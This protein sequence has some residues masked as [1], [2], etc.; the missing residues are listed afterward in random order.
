[1]LLKF[2]G[3]IDKRIIFDLLIIFLIGLLPVFWFH[4]GTI[5]LG[6]DAGL[7]FDPVVHF[8]DRFHVWSQ[9][10]G[11][12][13]DQSAALLGAFFIHGIEALLSSIG[14]N[15][16]DQQKTQFVFWFLIPGV[17]MYFSARKLWPEK[18][19]L[20]LF[21]AVI[22]MLNF[23]LLQGWFVAE[24]TKFSLYTAFPIVI[25]AVVYYLTGR[26]KLITAALVS[27]IVLGIFN[28]GGSIPLYGGLAVAVLLI[29]SYFF[30]FSP[31]LKF[32]KK[33]IFYTI[34]TSVIYFLLNAYWIIPYAF[35]LTGFA[36]RDLASAGGVEGALQWAKYL[37]AQSTF[38]N[39]FRGQGIPD[40][41]LNPY[42]AFSLNFFTNPILIA[43]SFALPI[44]AFSS[45]LVIRNKKEAL[46][47]YLFI[48]IAL[49]GILFSSGPESQLGIIYETLTRYVPGF[50]MFRSAFFKFN[51]IVWFSYGILIGFTLDKIIVFLQDKYFK[52]AKNIFAYVF[53]LAAILGY[54]LY[55]YPVLDGSFFDY[56]REPGFE[57][58]TRVKVP[59]YIFEFGNWINQRGPDERYLIM[60]QLGNTNYI[61]YDW[62]Y[63]SIA[64]ITS[65]IS[66]NSF[67]H[68]NALVS[69]EERL[70][71][72]EMYAA[73][74]KGDEQSFKDFADVFAID[75]I[76]LQKDFDW[77]NLRWGTV[78]PERYEKILD[79]SKLFKLEK[80][81]GKWKV[82]S[83]TDRD[84]SVRINASGKL[85][86]L[87]GKLEK[88]ASHPSFDPRSP[89]F[90]SELE[91]NNVDFYVK[92]ASEI[93]LAPE[94]QTCDLESDIPGFKYY[95][96]TI[97]PGSILYNFITFR[98][99]QIKNKSNDF[100]S[101]L[102]FYITT[103]N[104]RI[105]E[106]K[107]MIDSKNRIS[108]ILPTLNRYLERLKDLNN[109]LSQ[110][111]W[112]STAKEENIAA[113]TV[114]NHILQQITLMDSVYNS[115]LVGP[116]E[117][118]V[119]ALA[120][121]QTV[122]IEKKA[123]E[124]H[125][126]TED[127]PDKR[128]IYDMPKLGDYEL[129][130]KRGSLTNPGNDSSNTTITIRETSQVL[131]P[132]SI[133]EDW[134][135]FGHV[136]ITDKKLHINLFDATISNIL[137]NARIG[138][139]KDSDGIIISGNNATFL[140]NGLNKCFY[141]EVE[142]LNPADLYSL[143]F[144]YRNFSDKFK[145]AFVLQQEDEQFLEYS[146]R[147]SYVENSR[148]FNSFQRTIP[149][150]QSK[151]KLNFCG[152]FLSLPELK[153]KDVKEELDLLSQD[154]KLIEIEGITLEKI[155]SPN[156]VLYQKQKEADEENNLASYEKI[157]PVTYDINFLDGDEKTSLIMRESFGKY[158]Q[159]CNE[160]GDCL[161]FDDKSH[162][163]TGGFANA[164]FFSDG[165]GKHLKLY[166]YPQRMFT[167][168]VYITIISAGI[169]F[170]FICIKKLLKK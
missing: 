29:Y 166:Y 120:Y 41:Y 2:L 130:V 62:G 107:W 156:I 6:H 4:Q 140:T 126:T 31:N 77:K 164:W 85:T 71:M 40:W 17:S 42:H 56:S 57:L 5:I 155:A 35:Y 100:M 168:G 113:E 141:Y 58:T 61:S 134:L 138:F 43:G 45:M 160:Q 28:G 106:V 38:I 125:W 52:S 3:R 50:A 170:L 37:S 33:I 66:R 94:C 64:P 18:K 83:L 12:G 14:F 112:T 54:V 139:N 149:V 129:F 124:R 132:L 55:H 70:L 115:D 105:I 114:L 39:L 25:Y 74:L 9:R 96:P 78:D 162:F 137:N 36:G 167:I 65:L 133:E 23:Y 30:F 79:S 144:K 82:Y 119:I 103:S 89:L 101:L 46:Y 51:Y 81:F 122:E 72:N 27:G 86:F 63:W 121:D 76:V 19:Y 10:F 13:T 117:R 135:N 152:G 147:N 118:A 153:G 44:L 49:F 34:S 22:Y 68:N 145:L 26:M 92:E 128:Y 98:E 99:D 169:I 148:I 97:L 161:P 110:D 67:V 69:Q 111:E 48:L 47:I 127:L 109:L 165:F 21:A 158:W 75:G 136:N 157:D 146:A 7:P 154:G 143:T 11:I 142:N 15:L 53:L 102:N 91:N 20:P 159:I 1:M 151:I 16:Q 95:N 60:P 32:L 104:R 163:A 8:F 108:L 88:V 150:K 80:T 90:M 24:R 59:E 93:F 73:F 123:R 84:N 116:N 87:Q 131:R